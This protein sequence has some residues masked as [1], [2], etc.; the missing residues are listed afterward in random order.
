MQTNFIFAKEHPG[1]ET[2]PE[3]NRCF[4]LNFLLRASGVMIT[5]FSTGNKATIYCPVLP[6]PANQWCEVVRCP[7]AKQSICNHV[8]KK[9]CIRFFATSAILSSWNLSASYNVIPTIGN[10]RGQQ[11]GVEVVHY[12]IESLFVQANKW[13]V[14]CLPTSQLMSQWR[15][16]HK[17]RWKRNALKH[18]RRIS[19]KS[20]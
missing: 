18:K 13:E 14:V 11:G 8:S 5:E 15:L 3:G 7:L 10:W 20:E 4:F 17:N 2:L 9:E 1:L 16:A 12:W 6:F 19:I